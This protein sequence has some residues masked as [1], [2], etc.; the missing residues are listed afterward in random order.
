M[1]QCF[2]WCPPVGGHQAL[3][4]THNTCALPPSSLPPCHFFPIAPSFPSPWPCH[5]ISY[6]LYC[7][8]LLR[9]LQAS[10]ILYQQSSSG[11]ACGVPL[12]PKEQ[13]V[14]DM[15]STRCWEGFVLSKQPF[16]SN[17]LSF[18][19]QPAGQPQEIWL[20]PP[21]RK[22]FILPGAGLLHSPIQRTFVNTFT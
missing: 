22:L 6:L 2:H 20:I 14:I 5:C 18:S 4:H 3:G 8:H 12:Y 11:P 7:K 10:S 15:S 9:A 1:T 17:G 13:K 21:C 16:L 19:D